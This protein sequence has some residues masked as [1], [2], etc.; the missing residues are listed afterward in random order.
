MACPSTQ[1][2]TL[3]STH[4][5]PARTSIRTGA[6]TSPTASA[7]TSSPTRLRP[8]SPYLIMPMK[9]IR[10]PY[11]K[12]TT[13]SLIEGNSWSTSVNDGDRH[14]LLVDTHNDVLYELYST[15]ISGGVVHAGSGAIWPLNSNMLRPDGWTSADAAGLPVFPALI[16]YPETSAGPISH[17]M[18][19]TGQRQQW[20]YLARPPHCRHANAQLSAIWA[21]LQTEGKF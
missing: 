13:A 5:V 18:R 6:L 16:N 8:I 12:V 3:I 2:R 15:T 10:G 20:L 19:F 14:V 21:A 11:P 4:S 9:A 7:T 1:T 17:A